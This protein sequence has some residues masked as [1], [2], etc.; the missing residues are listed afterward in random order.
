MLRVLSLHLNGSSIPVF[1][2]LISGLACVWR[3]LLVVGYFRVIYHPVG[4][5]E[6]EVGVVV[7][8]SSDIQAECV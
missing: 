5:S 7:L 1:L 4:R 8:L 2:L 6:V 3:F